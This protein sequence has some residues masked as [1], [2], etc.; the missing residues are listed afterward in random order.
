MGWTVDLSFRPRREFFAELTANFRTE[1]GELVECLKKL[2][3][4]APHKGVLYTLWRRCDAAGQ[5]LYR[6]VVV[7]LIAI[8]RPDGWGYKDMSHDMCPY[9]FSCPLSWLEGLCLDSS[10]ARKWLDCVKEYWAAR[11]E[12]RPARIAEIIQREYT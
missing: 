10:G 12:K 5:E 1:R 11:R 6:Y 7:Y 8:C 9:N 3:R 2:Y 4:G